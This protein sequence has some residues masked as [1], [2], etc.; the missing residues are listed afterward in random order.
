[1]ELFFFDELVQLATQ[2]LAYLE[3]N[4]GQNM[5]KISR[6]L[7][8]FD[9][10]KNK[11]SIIEEQ[12]RCRDNLRFS[13]LTSSRDQNFSLIR[14]GSFLYNSYR[15]PDINEIN[16]VIRQRQLSNNDQSAVLQSIYFANPNLQL[17]HQSNST[18]IQ[19]NQ[20]PSLQS[21]IN[22]SFNPFPNNQLNQFDSLDSQQ[23]VSP[24]RLEEEKFLECNEQQASHIN[25]E[26]QSHQDLIVEE[27]DDLSEETGPLRINILN[28]NIMQQ[29]P[30]RKLSLSRGRSQNF[31]RMTESDLIANTKL[32]HQNNFLQLYPQT[33]HDERPSN[34]QH[35]SPQF[36]RH[37]FNP[38]VNSLKS[39]NGS[40][41]SSCHS[42]INSH[43][44][45]LNMLVNDK[46][47]IAKKL[48]KAHDTQSR[49]TS[50]A[51]EEF[52]FSSQKNYSIF[53]Q[54]M[55]HSSYSKYNGV[56]SVA[57]SAG[58]LSEQTNTPSPSKKNTNKKGQSNN[59][60]KF[61]TIE[62]QWQSEKLKLKESLFKSTDQNNENDENKKQ[63]VGFRFLRRLARVKI[64][65]DQN[66]IEEEDED[67]AQQ[68]CYMEPQLG[69]KVDTLESE[70]VTEVSL[71]NIARSPSIKELDL[72]EDDNEE[73]KIQIIEDF[74]ITQPPSQ[75]KDKYNR[76]EIKQTKQ[77]AQFKMILCEV[78]SA[79]PSQNPFHFQQQKMNSTSFE[80]LTDQQEI[81]NSEFI[82]EERKIFLT[83]GRLKED[84]QD[85][86]T[87]SISAPADSI[88]M[89]FQRAQSQFSPQQRQQSNS[90]KK[91][92]KN[93]KHSRS[94]CKVDRNL[95]PIFYK[96]LKNSLKELDSI[97][98]LG[99]NHQLDQQTS[100]NAYA[101]AR[102]N[103]DESAYMTSSSSFTK[104][105]KIERKDKQSNLVQQSKIKPRK[106]N[107]KKTISCLYDSSY[108]PQ[109]PIS[110]HAT[111]RQF[112]FTEVKG[113]EDVN[114]VSRDLDSLQMRMS[115]IFKGMNS[116][117]K[118]QLTSGSQNNTIRKINT[119]SR[120]PLIIDS[121]IIQEQFPITRRSGY[122]LEEFKKAGSITGKSL[123]SSEELSDFSVALNTNFIQ[124]RKY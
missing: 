109:N 123:Q 114:S 28:S 20:N 84:Q 38:S 72:N 23:L 18:N 110:A 40:G 33:P 70:S 66:V 75:R 83:S 27:Y 22:I 87:S 120:L 68:A 113:K 58:K 89:N 45:K 115:K 31:N 8:T 96:N 82:G 17:Q 34:A 90:L 93:V 44:E 46:I 35:H 78:G 30:Q 67:D 95:D 36:E 24:R 107:M 111:N 57:G 13:V 91:A 53:R 74:K 37:S 98:T 116:Q 3:S 6:E 106:L 47:Q 88:L 99:Q 63:E 77:K 10:G 105:K 92:G 61:K 7:L 76:E 121:G 59:K 12:K 80:P 119:T 108:N 103:S 102:K 1:M 42:P 117:S 51:D 97:I 2:N 21:Q 85:S 100:F 55:N 62:E 86:S 14:Q 29:N 122:L 101:R 50:Q 124:K 118:G 71:Q 81:L 4:Q 64:K 73:L 49:R 54:N 26:D 60:S 56:T 5:D 94:I 11:E 32:V 39:E 19:N 104:L 9:F 65:S 25:D 16:Q 43:L 69:G 15:V 41:S 79:S 48:K 52:M 112:L